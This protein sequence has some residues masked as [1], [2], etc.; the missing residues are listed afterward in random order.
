MSEPRPN[1][2][3][4]TDQAATY[5]VSMTDIMGRTSILPYCTNCTRSILDMIYGN[6]DESFAGP[7][8]VIASTK[9][10]MMAPELHKFYNMIGE[11][12]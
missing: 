6:N 8:Q 2:E 9:V 1:C 11:M 3:N 4:H 7:T 12:N 10:T 5:W